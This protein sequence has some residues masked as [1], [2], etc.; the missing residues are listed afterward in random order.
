MSNEIFR[1]T[2]AQIKYTSYFLPDPQWAERAMYRFFNSSVKLCKRVLRK[3]LLVRLKKCDVGTN[4]VEQCV[5]KLTRSSFRKVR[6]LET[7]K[8]IMSR[9]ILDAEYDIKKARIE[10]RKSEIEFCKRVPRVYDAHRSFLYIKKRETERVWE[11]GK[12]KNRNKIN[13]LVSRY[14]EGREYSAIRQI[15][16]S[17]GDLRQSGD[18]NSRSDDNEPRIYGGAEIGNQEIEILKK[19]PRFMTM[20]PIDE[21]EIEVEIEKGMAKARYELMNC[22]VEEDDQDDSIEEVNRTGNNTKQDLDTTL[23]YANLK[24]TD[25][26]TVQRLYPPKP[27]TIRNETIMST[28]KEKLMGSVGEYRNKHCNEKGIVKNQNITMGETVAMKQL[29]KRTKEKEIV[30]FTTDKSGR[31]SV[32][33][34]ENY[35]KA[36]GAHT[37]NDVEIDQEGVRMIENKMNQHMKQFNKMFKVGE[38]VEQESRVAGA[39]KSVNTPAP[40]LY[41]LRKD[42]KRTENEVEGPPVRP[43]CGANQAP[44]SRLSNFLSRIVND[45]ADTSGIATE[46]RSSEEMR[47]AFEEYNSRQPEERKDS[48]IISMDV[49]ALYPSMELDEVVSSVEEMIKTSERE[50][51]KV[52]YGE[53]GRYLAVTMTK[54]KIDEEGLQHVVPTRKRDTGRKI[55]VAYL[56]NRDNDDKW[57][58]P[59]APGVRQRKKMLAL[60]V[61]EGVRVCMSNHV[62][63]TGDRI[64]KQTNGG[65]IGLELTGAVSRAFMARWDRMYKDRVAKAGIKMSTYERYVDDSNQVAVVPPP[66]TEYDKERGRTVMNPNRQDVD[67]P[68]DERLANVLLEIANSIMPCIQMEADWPSRNSDM[69]MPIL[70]MKVWM[71]EEECIMYQHYEKEVSSKTVLHSQSAHPSSCKRSV[72]TQEVLRRLMNSSPKLNWSTEVAP[73]I[74]E[75][76]DRMRKAGYKEQYRKEVLQHALRIYDMKLKEHSDGVRPLCRPKEWKKEE[77]KL[78]KKR[79]KN[80][81]ATKGGHIAPIFVPTTPDGILAKR[82]RKICEEEGQGVIRFRIVESGGITLK[83]QLQKSNPTENIGCGDNECLGCGIERGKGGKC[84]KNNV[85][86]EIEC[87]RCPEGN[88]P[89]YIGETS[90]NLFT[91]CKEHMGANSSASDAESCFVKKHMEEFHEGEEGR[92]TARVTH[93]NKDSLTRQIRE[94]VLIRRAGSNT[95]NTKSEWFQPPLYRVESQ[96]VR[97]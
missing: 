90:R 94:G 40:P 76:M 92:F 73:V 14:R 67:K 10:Y 50:V 74:T 47:A 6:D 55:T 20:K 51:E 34:P 21:L 41:G 17:D 46:C 58:T 11:E 4:E 31:F 33:T 62:F 63:C 26:P 82:M 61:A 72:H 36:V 2:L 79:K 28:I 59:R 23:N 37:R 93:C 60:A 81:W 52:D 80:S 54:E 78:E 84:R 13:T 57:N 96:V 8:F 32:D 91:R 15:K 38:T 39:T 88:R 7:V 9:K 24:A 18:E 83:S 97:E 35:E 22:G 71:T 56:C 75:Y 86:Y 66:G 43:V 29:K 1:Q 3:D 87:Q 64:Y 49:K 68:K 45:Y 65:P 69:K 48:A 89:V 12:V 30:V 53:I 85:N 77:R 25:I 70:D 44:N 5:S 27:S 19:D 95:M 42:H 16:Y